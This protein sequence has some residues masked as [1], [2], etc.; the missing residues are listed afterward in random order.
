MR[1]LRPPRRHVRMPKPPPERQ[2]LPVTGV[3]NRLNRS[4]IET[5]P[6]QPADTLSRECLFNLPEIH[7]PVRQRSRPD[8]DPAMPMLPLERFKFPEPSLPPAAEWVPIE[9]QC[10]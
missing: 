7:Y 9:T 3:P 4:P 6:V 10:V 8:S 1:I 2:K 5:K